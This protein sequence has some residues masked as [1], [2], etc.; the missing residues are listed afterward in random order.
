MQTRRKHQWVKN[1]EEECACGSPRVGR[2]RQVCVCVRSK[3]ACAEL[4]KDLFDYSIPCEW[5]EIEKKY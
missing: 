5:D 3:L 2:A 4:C 1:P